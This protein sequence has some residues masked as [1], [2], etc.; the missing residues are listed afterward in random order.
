MIFKVTNKNLR[1]N[2]SF[3]NLNYIY[4]TTDKQIFLFNLKN[5]A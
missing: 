4:I 3:S 1:C 5:N 2:R